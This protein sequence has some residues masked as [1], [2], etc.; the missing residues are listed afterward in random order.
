[1]GIGSMLGFPVRGGRFRPPLGYR[2]TV[3]WLP[4]IGD[5]FPDFIA[6]STTGRISFHGW[7]EGKWT[8][9]FS[10]PAAFTPVCSTEIACFANAQEDFDARN[11]QVLG[12]SGNPVET[13]LAWHSDIERMFDVKVEF[14]V[15][16]DIAGELATGFGMIHANEA[17]VCPIR[18]SFIIDPALKVRMIFEYPIRVG[19]SS[20]ETLRVIDALQIIDRHE[21]ATPSDW[22]PGKKV[23]LPYG[24]SDEEATATYGSDWQKLSD[25]LKFVRLDA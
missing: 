19:R 16:E 13:Q 10:H 20:A 25:Y 4:C 21:V 23:I 6:N 9:F 1:M 15:I 22:M 7:A 17:E 5:I 8:F 14:P 3:A 2:R 12:L 11:V 18:K 24:M